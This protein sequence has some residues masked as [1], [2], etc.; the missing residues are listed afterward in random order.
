LQKAEEVYKS[1]LLPTGVYTYFIL[2]AVFIQLG[3]F[4]L[5]IAITAAIPMAYDSWILHQ[6]YM[7]L[8]VNQEKEK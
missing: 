5:P 2:F 8:R 1:T 6:F 7:T 4:K 3:I